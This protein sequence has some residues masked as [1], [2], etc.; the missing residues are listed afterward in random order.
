VIGGVRAGPPRVTIVMPSRNQGRFIAAAIESVLGQ[1]YPALELL[2]VDGVSTDN[3]IEILRAYGDRVRWISEPDGGQGDAIDKGILLTD[4]DIIGWLN[5]DDLYEPTAVSSAVAA[6]GA[7]PEAPAVY[8]NAQFVDADNRVL[9]PCAQV[10]P[11]DFRRLVNELDFI[12]QPATF[13]RRDAYLATGGIDRSLNYCLDYDLWIRLGLQA[14]LEHIDQLVASVRVYPET[15]TAG[16]GLSRLREIERMVRKHGRSRLPRDFQREAVTEARRELG[17]AVDARRWGDTMPPLRFLARY[18]P[19]TVQRR[20]FTKLRRIL[21]RLR[22]LVR[23][24]EVP[25]GRL[26]AFA[27]AEL[28]KGV[29]TSIASAPKTVAIVVPCF[30]HAAYLPA[31]FASITGQT[32]RPDEVVFVDDASND[33]TAD[34]LQAL[35]AKLPKSTRGKYRVLRND[36]NE[37]QAASLNRAVEAT[38]SD[39][40]MVLNDDDYLMHDAV[41]VALDLFSRYREIA[42]IGA[43]S[44]HFDAADDPRTM[45]PNTIAWQLGQRTLALD[46]RTPADSFSYRRFNDLNMTNS[47]SCFLRVAWAAV[48]G[49]NPNAKERVVPFS[50]RDFQL[51][52]NALYPVGLSHDISF[53]FWRRG[54]SVDH[55]RNT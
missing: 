32:R 6:F 36:D 39:A 10:G 40:I 48:A 13:F 51:R 18:W 2:V 3:T 15:K 20:L 7:R 49:F 22:A 24:P 1:D 4:G 44:V 12:V 33:G 41:D 54:S 21:G 53:A 29:M 19:S 31:M 37:G 28:D 14:P 38:S 17:A 52:I 16:G 34:I 8:G 45:T 11:Y 25:R 47:G 50:D 46:L 42:L 27:S 55:G 35:I 26:R 23:G 30:G 9:G 5:S 43:T